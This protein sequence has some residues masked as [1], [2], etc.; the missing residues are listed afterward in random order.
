MIKRHDGR[1]AADV[2]P[3]TCILNPF[4]YADG[5]V[6]LKLGKTQVYCAVTLQQGVP[7][8]LRGQGIGWLTA[9]YS[10]LPT[11]TQ[12]RKPRDG[13]TMRLN[14]RSVEISRLIGRVLRS[15]V[16]VN[17]LG[18]RTI[19][20]DCDVLQADGGTRTACITAAYIALRR[21]TQQWMANGFLK[22]SILT[23]ELAAISVGI[24]DNDV[25]LD[26]DY[27][28]DNSVDADF[29]FVLTRSGSIIEV[30]GTA[31][32]KPI[33]W[34]LFERA[35]LLA[36][37]GVESLCSS[38][39]DATPGSLGHDEDPLSGISSNAGVRHAESKAALFS[40]QN[41]QNSSSSS[42]R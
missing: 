14:G 11:S 29:N 2:R 23:D 1:G 24:R 19:T 22:H 31:E 39:Y 38:L 12:V 9:E 26:V 10:L 32:K 25:L 15:V 27:Q 4:G 3:V 21:A 40:L 16:N 42:S 30:Q 41:R 8:F 28:E 18:E 35:R 34:E 33:S 13:N 37:Q 17:A 20:I 6:L 5:S 7:P 36:Q